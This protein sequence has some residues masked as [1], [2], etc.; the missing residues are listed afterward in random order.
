MKAKA[1]RPA[2]E[3]SRALLTTSTPSSTLGGTKILVL[4]ADDKG[5][6]SAKP[7][8]DRTVKGGRRHQPLGNNRRCG[9]IGRRRTICIRSIGVC[10]RPS[11][12]KGVITIRQTCMSGTTSRSRASSRPRRCAGHPE[13]TPT[14]RASPSMIRRVRGSGT[15]LRHA[16]LHR[17]RHY[18]RQRTGFWASGAAERSAT[19]VASDGPRAAPPLFAS[20][21]GVGTSMRAAA[22]LIA[23]PISPAPLASPSTTL[24]S[25]RPTSTCEPEVR[26]RQ[27]LIH[28]GLY[29]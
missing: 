21:N 7:A 1:E 22:S 25:T 9:E 18:H 20:N 27:A 29:V 4:I 11:N 5:M 28:A 2:R 16:T 3:A 13:T 10:T 12:L 23:R 14:A 8:P 24:R 26:R 17:W 19:S 15:C 6:L